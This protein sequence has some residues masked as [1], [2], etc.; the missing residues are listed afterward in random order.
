[1]DKHYAPIPRVIKKCAFTVISY[2]VAE[3]LFIHLGSANYFTPLDVQA[4]RSAYAERTRFECRRGVSKLT[5]GKRMFR[6]R[7]HKAENT[8]S[9]FTRD[10]SYAC[11]CI[12]HFVYEAKLTSICC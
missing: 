12:V 11:F 6:F 1:M 7:N 9:N 8:S 5:E 3:H 2:S 10:L 4:N